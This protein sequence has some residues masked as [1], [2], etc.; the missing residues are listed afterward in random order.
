MAKHILLV[1]DEEEFRFSAGVALRQAGYRIDMAGDGREALEK[2]LVSRE[3]TEPFDLLV[4]DIRMPGMS[5]TELIDEL[6]SRDIS[7]PVFVMTCFGDKALLDELG[8]KGC[9]AVIEKPFRPR[10]LVDRIASLL[11]GG[12]VPWEKNPD[13]F[14]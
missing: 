14:S 2:I 6:R 10:D 12:D 8:S 1:D 13:F 7:L 5:G 9:R 4:L 3:G 11:E